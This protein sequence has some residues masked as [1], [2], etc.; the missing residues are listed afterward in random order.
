MKE[1]KKTIIS[2]N[3]EKEFDKI[4]HILMI[5]NSEVWTQRRI[6]TLGKSWQNMALRLC[7]SI[8]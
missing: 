4:Q 7:D 3:S 5:H 1:R 2:K 6:S 8:L